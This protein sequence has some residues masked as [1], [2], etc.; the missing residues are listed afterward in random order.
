MKLTASDRKALIKLAGDLPKGSEER[1][2]IL[3]G[4]QKTAAQVNISSLSTLWKLFGLMLHF[5]D[6]R[7]DARLFGKAEDD[8]AKKRYNDRLLGLYALAVEQGFEPGMTIEEHMED[9]GLERDESE[10]EG[11]GNPPLP[12]SFP[13]SVTKAIESLF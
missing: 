12:R 10:V 4:L 9:R 3:A 6:D 8:L 11:L 13:S 7:V 2:A 5:Q 1:K